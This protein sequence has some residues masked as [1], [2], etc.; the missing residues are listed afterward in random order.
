MYEWYFCIFNLIKMLFRGDFEE[1]S[2]NVSINCYFLSWKIFEFLGYGH[3]PVPH[4]CCICI[5]YPCNSDLNIYN[6]AF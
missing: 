5:L 3:I 2:I 4:Q 6:V 1:T